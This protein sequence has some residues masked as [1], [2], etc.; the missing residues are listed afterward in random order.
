MPFDKIPD[1][2]IRR[3][4]LQMLDQKKA[5]VTEKMVKAKDDMAERFKQLEE[6]GKFAISPQR[7][8]E[9]KGKMAEGIKRMEEKIAE[10]PE[11][12]EQF[13]SYVEK[14]RRDSDED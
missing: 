6:D 2:D 9:L 14:S 3:E 12:I 7:G 1:K 8:D 4:L 13:T 10:I 5:E 11:V